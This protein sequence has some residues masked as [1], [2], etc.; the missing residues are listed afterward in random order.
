MLK[1]TLGI[2]VSCPQL[3]VCLS[4]ID[5]SQKVTIK[6]CC[7]FTNNKAGF[8]ELVQWIRKHHKEPTIPL[9]VVMEATGIYYESCALFVHESGYKVSVVLPNKAKKYL[10]AIG[11]KSKNDTIDA[12]GLARMG[13]EQCLEQWQP[14]SQYYHHLKALTRHYQSLQE[15][16]TAI[17]NQLHAEQKGMYVNKLVVR[18]LKATINS[19]EKQIKAITTAI[20]KHLNSNAQVADK[21]SHIAA[22][23]GVSTLTIAVI[24]AE[25]DGFALFKNSSQ[26]VSYAGLDVVEN[27]SGN[28]HGK[29][30][31]SKKGNSRIRRALYMP[32]LIVVKCKVKPFKDLFDRTLLKHHIKMKSYVAVQKKLLIIIYT[33][34]KNNTSFIEDYTRAEQRQLVI[35]A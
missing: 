17:S 26:L 12:S 11:L 29:T 7:K 5:A 18:Q 33:L 24:L 35:V 23:K 9:T 19:L 4:V 16:K 15:M 2:D 27:Q 32:S 25:T 3:H 28:H 31:I 14:I 34:W 21:V 30:R 20:D 8:K 6:A 10:Q 13:A 22:I 1:Y